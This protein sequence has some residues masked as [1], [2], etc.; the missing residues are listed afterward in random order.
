MIATR[1]HGQRYLTLLLLV[2]TAILGKIEPTF[3]LDKIAFHELA[4]SFSA[5]HHQEATA[6]NVPPSLNHARP[7]YAAG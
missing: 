6:R 1:Y 7:R 4:M 3:P 2:K 5:L